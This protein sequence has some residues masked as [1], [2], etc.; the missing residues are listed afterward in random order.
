MVSRLGVIGMG[1]ASKQLEVAGQVEWKEAGYLGGGDPGAGWAAG[2]PLGRNRGAW[3][4]KE[5]RLCRSE[6]GSG[7]SVCCDNREPC[8]RETTCGEQCVMGCVGAEVGDAPGKRGEGGCHG[9]GAF[10]SRA[11]W[12]FSH[13]WCEGGETRSGRPACC[14]DRYQVGDGSLGH[15]KR[16]AEPCAS[17][18]LRAP[19]KW[20]RQGVKWNP[21]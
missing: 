3:M 17:V 6:G 7:T 9:D 21:V 15:S 10:R 1:A 11:T 20:E 13:A 12:R 14:R 4:D 19:W 5:S 2:F 18:P 16:I 8:T